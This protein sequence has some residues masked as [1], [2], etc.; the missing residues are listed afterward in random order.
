MYLNACALAVPCVPPTMERF[1]SAFK[2]FSSLQEDGYSLLGRLEGHTNAINCLSFSRDGSLLASGGKPS[3][4]SK[5]FLA[6]HLQVTM[7]GY[8]YGTLKHLYASRSLAILR[9]NGGRSPVSTGCLA[10]KNATGMP[11]AWVPG[12][13]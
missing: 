5:L 7:N 13:A 4:N 6:K 3:M 12:E 9:R 1:I 11:Y 10:A 2:K 8:A